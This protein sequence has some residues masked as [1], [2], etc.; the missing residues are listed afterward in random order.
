MAELTKACVGEGRDGYMF[1]IAFN[2]EE[3][4]LGEICC[5]ISVR[6]SELHA[7]DDLVWGKRWHFA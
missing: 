6:S 1:S 5:E 2:T 7:L 4:N 3:I